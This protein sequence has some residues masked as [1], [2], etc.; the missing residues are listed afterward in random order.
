M[1]CNIHLYREKFVAGKWVTADEWKDEY[2]DGQDVPF[3]K[4]FTTRSYSLFAILAGVRERETPVFKLKPR[5]MPIAACS[6]VVAACDNYGNDGHSHSY[7]YLHELTE[8]ANLLASNKQMISGMMHR[9]QLKRLEASIASRSPD[10]NML[11]PY[12]QSTNAPGHIEFKVAVPA[13]F[14]VGRHL[15]EIIDSLTDI[16]GDQQRIV[17]WF[18]N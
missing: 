12:S 18:D 11:F 7:L 13:D 6:E 14:L 8:L 5:G 10:W 2:G 1:G 3:E 16:G 4:R 9:E 17:F 15:K